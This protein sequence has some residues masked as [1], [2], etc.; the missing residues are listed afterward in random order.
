MKL[1]IIYCKFNRNII[2]YFYMKWLRKLRQFEWIGCWDYIIILKIIKKEKLIHS[3][4]A[5][6]PIC[7]YILYII[8]SVLQHYE[9]FYITRTFIQKK[10]KWIIDNNMPTN[11]VQLTILCETKNGN[12]EEFDWYFTNRQCLCLST[13]TELPCLPSC[14]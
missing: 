1:H 6:L 12:V 9:Q 8:Y 11:V 13:H 14:K 4:I 3:I 10:K 5:R 2:K 7:W